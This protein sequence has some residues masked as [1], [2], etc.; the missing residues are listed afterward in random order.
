MEGG[1]VIII[2]LVIGVPLV[3][4]IWLITRA[5]QAGNEISELSRRLG[6]MEVELSRLKEHRPPESAYRPI[7]SAAAET[8]K[9]FASPPPEPE[10]EPPPVSPVFT[11]RWWSWCC[12]W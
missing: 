6:T 7:K 11:T 2:L 5:I 9:S 12:W 10:T 8:A 1:I 4:A 3:I